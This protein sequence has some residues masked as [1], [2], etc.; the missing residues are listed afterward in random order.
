[1]IREH[2]A[3]SVQEMPTRLLQITP[4]ERRVLQLL[5]SGSS[6]SE[7]ARALRLDVSTLDTLLSELFARMGVSGTAAAIESASRRGLLMHTDVSSDVVRRY[8]VLR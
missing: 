6:P 8:R 4:P 3:A 5:A 7:V 1:V 2:S